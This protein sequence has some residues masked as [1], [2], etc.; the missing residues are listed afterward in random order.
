MIRKLFVLLI[1]VLIGLPAFADTVVDT[2]WVRIY[3]GPGNEDDLAY[4]MAVDSSGNVYVTGR[5][6]LSWPNYG[7]ATV[8]YHPNGDTAWVRTYIGPDSSD[9][10]ASAVAVDDSG[11]IYV[12]GYSYGNATLEDYATIK[13]YP[14][15]DTAWVR[16][17]NGPGNGE[18]RPS[19]IAVDDSG[20]VYLTGRSYGGSL[21]GADY[22][23]I[24]Y[25]PNGDTAW[26]RRYNG[27]GNYFDYAEAIAL[28]DFGNVYVT[29]G[30]YGS[31]TSWDYATIKYYSNGDTAWIRRYNSPAD[32]E[33]YAQAIAID[34]LGNVCV[35][36]LSSGTV[37]YDSDGNQ[38]WVEPW[39]GIAVAVDHLGN[40]LVAGW[41]YSGPT[42]YDYATTKYYPDGDTAW[43]R[44]YN[45]PGNW[46][47]EPS[48]IAVDDSGNVFVTG[49]LGSEATWDY[50]T[51][52]YDSDGDT[53]WVR[54]YN[55]SGNDEDKAS[56]IAVDHS[57]SV[58][59]AGWSTGS[60]TAADYATIKY[61]Q[62]GPGP[63]PRVVSTD[64]DVSVTFDIEMDP[65]TLNDSTFVVNAWSTGLHRGA[66][67][68][69]SPTKTVTLN[70]DHDFDEGE[71]VTVV[72]TAGIRSSAGTAMESSYVWSFTAEVDDGAGCF[73]PPIGYDAG[74]TPRSVF[75]ADLDGDGDLDLAVANA[76]ADSV[77]ILKNNGDGTFQTKVGYGSGGAPF[78]VCCADLDGDTHLDLVTANYDSDNVSVLENNG[79]GTF[80]NKVD[81]GAGDYPCDVFCADLNGDGHLDLAV[82]NGL[83]LFVS[84]L[85]NNG[86]GTFQTAVNY[87]A[88]GYPWAVS[89]ADL[90]ADG[91]LDLAV[92]N[93]YPG[94]VS[95]LKNN[96][97]G[98]FQTK[99]DYVTAGAQGGSFSV[100][101]A[102]L[103]GDGDLDIAVGTNYSYNSSAVHVL[104]NQG[105]G[106]FLADYPYGIG[107]NST[108]IFCADL[109]GDSD[110]DIAVTDYYFT[111]VAILENDGDGTFQS[112]SYCDVGDACSSVFCADLDG[113]GDLDFAVGNHESGR[114]SV[115]LNIR[116]GDCTDD[117][118]VNVGDVIF[119]L[120]YLFKSGPIP[121]P[122]PVGDVNCD[123]IDDLGDVVYLLNYFFKGGPEPCC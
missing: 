2:A 86:D 93:D 23:T 70:P 20:N 41:S 58:Y 73:A 100:F 67:T 94:S 72:L 90:D 27:P 9:D 106:T 77:S 45:G 121:V 28:D 114:V 103:D 96:G 30:S 25:R 40:V 83:S 87:D 46:I 108:S 31:G 57:N 78:S 118:T 19:A 34:S 109:D 76:D 11:H 82:A 8:K 39:G 102:D 62:S 56:D 71:I 15:G 52:A 60:G 36:G 44:L 12:T 32:G 122:L 17:Y 55:G 113:D 7:Y 98:T 69:D 63:S 43:I 99:V 79:D 51:I 65:T 49:N 74:D 117:Q 111:T 59:V 54:T 13:Y 24:K 101:C 107:Y 35:T 14:N 53:L 29:G 84:V 61:R 123:G 89:C 119:L 18:D 22:A 88:G 6:Y 47:D 104:K 26:V 91:D 95:I 80:Q 68:Y 81:Y 75:C 4:D 105:D 120:N 64:A 92:A 97:D 112:A 10:G 48:D 50:G 116:R 38:L 85:L 115:L 42:Y 16:R 21:V 1:S 5:G 110:L 37:K 66:I 3:N 33:D